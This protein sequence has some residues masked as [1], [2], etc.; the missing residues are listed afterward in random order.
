M[1]M[2]VDSLAKRMSV[3]LTIVAEADSVFAQQAMALECGCYML[4]G[5]NAFAA[6][7]NEG[8]FSSAAIRNPHIHRRLVLL[9]VQQKPLSRAARDV[10]SFVTSMLRERR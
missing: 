8:H 1:R 5:E 4:R 9:T 10:A 3:K 7:K 2:V 6:G